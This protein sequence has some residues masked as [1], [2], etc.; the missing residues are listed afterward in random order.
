ME[1]LT[2]ERMGVQITEPLR[3]EDVENLADVLCLVF[4]PADA[5]SF[6]TVE[7]LDKKLPASV[8]RV[9]LGLKADVPESPAEGEPVKEAAAK[10]VAA[11]DALAAKQFPGAGVCSDD[12]SILEAMALLVSTSLRPYVA[13]GSRSLG[14]RWPA[15]NGSS[16][17]ATGPRTRGPAA[18]GSGPPCW[19]ASGWAWSPWAWSPWRTRRR[20]RRSGTP[21]SPRSPR[22]AASRAAQGDGAVGLWVSTARSRRAGEGKRDRD[23][24]AS[25]TG[26]A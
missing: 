14:W 15:S 6:Q 19:S 26:W 13:G 24:C 3:D 4:D 5:E 23:R 10:D 7:E 20:R 11:K 8:P 12:K 22:S 17:R 25:T 21:G 1:G 9:L 16:M 18:R 2:I